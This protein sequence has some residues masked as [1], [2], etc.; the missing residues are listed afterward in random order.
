MAVI[1]AIWIHSRRGIIAVTGDISRQEVVAVTGAISRQDIVVV[2][3]AMCIG[4]R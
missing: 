1:V 4:S 3:E 2:I